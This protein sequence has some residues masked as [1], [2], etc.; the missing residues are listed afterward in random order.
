MDRSA[1]PPPHCARAATADL[2]ITGIREVMDLSPDD[3]M[4][5]IEG[6]LASV[7]VSRDY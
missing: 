4:D 3:I 5:G 7:T 2:G 1:P 6:V